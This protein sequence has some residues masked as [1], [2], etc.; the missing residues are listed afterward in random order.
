MVKKYLDEGPDLW[1]WY[2][3]YGE[4]FT[5]PLILIALVILGFG[6]YDDNRLQEEIN[7]S[8]GWEEEDYKCVC[9]Q[10]AY[11]EYSNL[12][13]LSSLNISLIDNYSILNSS[14]WKQ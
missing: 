8:C 1:V 14:P 2:K 13:G 9:T 4:H 3:K 6:L 10:S 11:Q 12:N 5:A 7:L